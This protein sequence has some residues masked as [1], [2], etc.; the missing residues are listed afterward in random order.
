[1]FTSRLGS[2]IALPI[3]WRYRQAHRS[4]RPAA[5]RAC[6]RWTWKRLPIAILIPAFL[7]CASSSVARSYDKGETLPAVSPQ[8]EKIITEQTGRFALLLVVDAEGRVTP[9]RSNKVQGAILD[10]FTP[11]P[12]KTIKSLDS[13]AQLTYQGSYCILRKIGGRYVWINV[14]GGPISE[15]LQ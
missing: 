2:V 7:G 13:E 11:L 14:T 9:L 12:A 10:H 5:R 8:A 4:H 1:L 15:C 3:A 6:L